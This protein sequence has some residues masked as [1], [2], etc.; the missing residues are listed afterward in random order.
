MSVV[1]LQS[2][3]RNSDVFIN[4]MIYTLWY[5]SFHLGAYFYNGFT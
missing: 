3:L 2:D 5:E 4:V 1:Q